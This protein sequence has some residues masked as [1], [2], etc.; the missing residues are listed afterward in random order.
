[1]I[2]FD[3]FLYSAI[4]YIIYLEWWFLYA[5]EFIIC[6][7]RILE[8]INKILSNNSV[9]YW[10]SI[11]FYF[12]FHLYSSGIHFLIPKIFFSILNNLKKQKEFSRGWMTFTVIYSKS[13]K[14]AYWI[15][16]DMPLFVKFGAVIKGF[17]ELN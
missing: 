5:C 16:G 4:S 10:I 3:V 14:D 15:P 17:W 1:M 6:F 9:N 13:W 2:F 12:V 11:V 7:N 8:Y